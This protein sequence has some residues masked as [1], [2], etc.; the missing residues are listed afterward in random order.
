MTTL[1]NQATEKQEHEYRASQYS[2]KVSNKAERACNVLVSNV[3]LNKK[4]G[5]PRVRAGWSK[6]EE[7]GNET[8]EA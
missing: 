8:D 4:T 3:T 1:D 2:E 6:R 5:D 7:S